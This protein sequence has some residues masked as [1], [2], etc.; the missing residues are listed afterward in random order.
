[1]RA[2]SSP[3]RTRSSGLGL[4]IGNAS[5]AA[6]VRDSCRYSKPAI[7]PGVLAGPVILTK[8][9]QALPLIHRSRAPRASRLHATRVRRSSPRRTLAR[10]LR[11]Y[12]H[13]S[14]N[15]SG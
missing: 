3:K 8:Y 2:T 14:A 9:D 13:A 4:R 5:A 11:A 15:P 10:A 12:S 7:Q 1:M 6:M